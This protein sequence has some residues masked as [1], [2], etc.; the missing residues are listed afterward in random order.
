MN[1]NLDCFCTKIKVGP[2]IT[3][4]KCS[5]DF[6]NYQEKWSSHT[7]APL[8]MSINGFSMHRK[9]ALTEFDNFY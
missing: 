6:G 3:T 7:V 1:L 4:Y 5:E 9:V 2:L 8:G